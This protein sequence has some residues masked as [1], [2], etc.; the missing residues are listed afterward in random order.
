MW[1]IPSLSAESTELPHPFGALSPYTLLWICLQH[2]FLPVLRRIPFGIRRKRFF[3]RFYFRSAP[4]KT[5]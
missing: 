1:S 5:A 4:H 3:R 2:I